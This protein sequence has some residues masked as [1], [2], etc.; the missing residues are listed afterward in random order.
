MLYVQKSE[1]EFRL[2]SSCETP[3]RKLMITR[4]L[5]FLCISSLGWISDRP[6]EIELKK[7]LWIIFSLT[8]LFCRLRG[9]KLGRQMTHTNTRTQRHSYT[10]SWISELPDLCSLLLFSFLKVKN[11]TNGARPMVEQLS[12]HVPLRQPGVCWL[13]SW[14]GTYALLGKPCSG[15]HPTYKVEE[16]GHGC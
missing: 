10:R 4:P 11:L 2:W 14:V 13:G 12:S 5:L 16:D 6:K 8:I 3:L 1:L 9:W 7:T 15:R